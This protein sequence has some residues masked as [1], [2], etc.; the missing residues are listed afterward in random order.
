MGV[1][2]TLGFLEDFWFAADLWRVLCNM[3]SFLTFKKLTAGDRHHPHHRERALETG[4]W[5][6]VASV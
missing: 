4:N 1:P 6:M 3:G 5:L 2:E